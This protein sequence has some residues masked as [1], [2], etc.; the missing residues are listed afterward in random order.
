[1]TVWP[2]ELGQLLPEKD[3]SGGRPHRRA[4]RSARP[5]PRAGLPSLG[6]VS[7]ARGPLG[8]LARELF[9]GARM[10]AP[11]RRLTRTGYGVAGA[12]A[13]RARCLRRLAPPLPS[14]GRNSLRL[15]IRRR[16]G[17]ACP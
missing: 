15:E 17:F 3:Y 14:P 7:R 11:A 13:E 9:P 1:M 12:I 2:V 16:K 8:A 5:C 6:E 4:R 10:N